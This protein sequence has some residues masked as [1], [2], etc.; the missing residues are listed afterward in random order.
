MI[1]DYPYC[2]ICNKRVGLEVHH[3]IEGNAK[4]QL[5]DED[6]LTVTLCNECHR[7]DKFTSVHLNYAVNRWSKICGQLAYERDRCAEGM[8]VEEARNAFRERYGKSYL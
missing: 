2:I 7:S 4:R 6:G 3:L 5:S 8:T 1:T